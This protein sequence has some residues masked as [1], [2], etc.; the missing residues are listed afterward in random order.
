MRWEIFK[1]S[2]LVAMFFDKTFAQAYLVWLDSCGFTGYRIVSRA[3]PIHF[4]PN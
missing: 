2:I 1:G 4:Q 3:G